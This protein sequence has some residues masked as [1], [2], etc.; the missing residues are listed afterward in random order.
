MDIRVGSH[1]GNDAK[2]RFL[3]TLSWD[4]GDQ[5]SQSAGQRT[6]LFFTNKAKGFG[7]FGKGIDYY[8]CAACVAL[9]WH[10]KQ[11][12]SAE[13][14]FASA[15]EYVAKDCAT[16]LALGQVGHANISAEA[17][18]AAHRGFHAHLS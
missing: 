9:F 11:L 18:E 13:K 4:G 10:L 15:L 17:V 1:R 5:W 3:N 6:G 2:K 14:N 16:V 12:R 7:F 8:A